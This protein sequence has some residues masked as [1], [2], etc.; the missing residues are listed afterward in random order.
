MG[1]CMINLLPLI[2]TQIIS[3]IKSIKMIALEL[4]FSHY[5]LSHFPTNLTTKLTDITTKNEIR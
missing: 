3:Q 5:S 1:N 4:Y 2:T